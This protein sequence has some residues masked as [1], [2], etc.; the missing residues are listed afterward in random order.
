MRSSDIGRF[1]HQ[2]GAARIKRAIGAWHTAKR[3]KSG[4]I[5]GLRLF[6]LIAARKRRAAPRCL[7]VGP[8]GTALR[9]SPRRREKRLK[10]FFA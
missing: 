4:R 7:G 1:L 2:I 6:E 8:G 10:R 9:Y 3:M 5:Y